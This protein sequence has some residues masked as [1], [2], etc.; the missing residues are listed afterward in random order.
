[1][2]WVLLPVAMLVVS[3]LVMLG[4]LGRLESLVVTMLI[5]MRQMERDE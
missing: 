3:H 2:I 5:E 4:R 1:M